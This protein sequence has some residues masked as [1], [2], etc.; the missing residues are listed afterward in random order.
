MLLKIAL[1]YPTSAL[2]ADDSSSAPQVTPS[3]T[4][5][6]MARIM[7][8]DVTLDNLSDYEAQVRRDLPIGTPKGE[9]EA[10][11][12]HYNIPHSFIPP[13]TVYPPASNSFQATLENIGVRIIFPAGLLMKIFLDDQDKVREITFHV[14]YDAP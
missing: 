14:E 10:Y 7:P 2:F 3:E 5:A 9:V 1:A 11:L 8:S 12:D 6:N 13:N 4:D